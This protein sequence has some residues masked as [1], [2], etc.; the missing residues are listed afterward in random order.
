MFP[1]CT[2]FHSSLLF[3]LEQ[4]NKQTNK[5]TFHNLTALLLFLAIFFSLLVLSM[6]LQLFQ[7][8]LLKQEFL[9]TPL[10]CSITIL[11]KKVFPP[12]LIFLHYHMYEQLIFFSDIPIHTYA[13]KTITGICCPFESHTL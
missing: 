12:I 13:N 4:T 6:T 1:N 8:L 2:F 5:G 3:L 7:D 11:N 10:L 9:C